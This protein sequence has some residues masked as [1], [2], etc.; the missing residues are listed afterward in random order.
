MNQEGIVSLPL[1]PV[2]AYG[3]EWTEEEKQEIRFL[4]KMYDGPAGIAGNVGII[5]KPRQGKTAFEVWQGVKLHKYFGF[6][7]LANF[8]VKPAFPYPI[9]Y[10]D[11]NDF[12]EDQVKMLEAVDSMKKQT[13]GSAVAVDSLWQKADIRLRRSV[14]MLDE[15][16]KKLDRRK[17]MKGHVIKYTHTMAEW[18][19]FQFVM[20]MAG[21]LQEMIEGIRFWPLLTH[22]V[23]A[24]YFKDYLGT[25]IPMSRYEILN[26]YTGKTSQLFID[27]SIWSKLYD[28][29]VMIAPA[30]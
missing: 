13:E 3:R 25:G 28:S 19:H 20:L 24:T 5:A 7:I 1:D 14:I 27:I 9:R 17:F 30:R 10:F 12:D 2:K 18:G 29:Y 8:H 26:R 4:M 22:E 16:Q 6:P 15:I 21:P 23:G 11:D